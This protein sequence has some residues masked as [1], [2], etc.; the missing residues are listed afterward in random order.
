MKILAGAALASAALL[1]PATAQ[2][3]PASGSMRISAYVPA[4]CNIDA[5][6]FAVSGTN[7]QASGTVQEFCNAGVA[8]VVMASYRPLEPG[9]QV[10]LSYDGEISQLAPSGMSTVAFRQGPRLSTVPVTIQSSGL[11]SGLAVGF[12][13]TAM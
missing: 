6:T 10:A 7:G 1:V 9:E 3:E 2:A 12:A 8:F 4:V 11:H 13:M 5:D